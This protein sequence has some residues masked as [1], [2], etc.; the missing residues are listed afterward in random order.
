ME[1]A[2]ILQ[3]LLDTFRELEEITYVNVRDELVLGEFIK[4]ISKM[5]LD[6]PD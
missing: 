2:E 4:Q 5:I 6:E 1:R 3:G